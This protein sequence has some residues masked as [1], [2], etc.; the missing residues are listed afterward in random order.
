MDNQII[1]VQNTQEPQVLLPVNTFSEEIHNKFPKIP[2]DTKCNGKVHRQL[3]YCKKQAGWGTKHFGNGRCKLHGGCS[4]G[5]KSGNLR[6]SDFVP[7]A[8]VEKYEEFSVEDDKE[9][10]S[11]N[12][13]I[14]LIR[15]KIT[16]IESINSKGEF[17]GKICQ[18]VELVRRLAESKQ[19]IEEGIKQKIEI[20]I[21][22]RVIDSVIKI[23]D[24]TV[25]D[26]DMK[27]RIATEM[28][29]LNLSELSLN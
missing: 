28:R 18:M 21:V 11:L 2:P 26:I 3:R 29:R 9:I 20:E 24:D 22:H 15:A 19:K 5:R 25:Q 12:N 8:L 17:D 6:Y 27:K 14:A 1:P 23:I 10:K 16:G 4:T 13:E 7:S